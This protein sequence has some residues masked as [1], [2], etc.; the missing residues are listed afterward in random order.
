MSMRHVRQHKNRTATRGFSC[1]NDGFHSLSSYSDLTP[2][3]L[4]LKK[5]CYVTQTFSSSTLLTPTINWTTEYHGRNT[6]YTMNI[7]CYRFSVNKVLCEYTQY[8]EYDTI[9]RII[10]SYAVQDYSENTIKYRN[11][12]IDVNTCNHA[13]CTNPFWTNDEFSSNVQY[14]YLGLYRMRVDSVCVSVITL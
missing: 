6:I 9:Q 3:P 2:P 14:I 12:T 10:S 13:T 8:S 5:K 4:G 1:L 7:F 11:V